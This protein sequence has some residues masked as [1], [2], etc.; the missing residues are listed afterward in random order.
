MK[1]IRE[2]I[3]WTT[4]SSEHNDVIRYE[5]T[6]M[7]YIR[8]PNSIETSGERRTVTELDSELPTYPRRRIKS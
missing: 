8:M 6:K 2:E 1:T 5:S 3:T 7:D 4:I